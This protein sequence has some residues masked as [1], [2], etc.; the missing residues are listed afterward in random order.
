MGAAYISSD[1]PG[2]GVY[3]RANA[4]KIGAEREE[5][6]LAKRTG[7]GGH[8]PRWGSQMTKWKGQKETKKNDHGG[9]FSRVQKR[10]FLENHR[11]KGP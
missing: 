9:F 7:G 1:L 4:V 2:D 11:K 8:G 5:T 3:R 6:K 10:I